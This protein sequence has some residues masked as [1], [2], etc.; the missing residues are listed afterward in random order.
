MNKVKVTKL[1]HK[2][3]RMVHYQYFRFKR[4][5]RNGKSYAV[6]TWGWVQ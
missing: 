1:I 6:I 5:E 4:N 3:E 2:F